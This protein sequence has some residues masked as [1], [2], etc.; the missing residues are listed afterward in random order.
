[1]KVRSSAL[2]ALLLLASSIT[3]A[4]QAAAPRPITV[5]DLFNVKEA[6]EARINPDG[7]AI[8]FTVHSTSLKEDKPE[9]RIW[10]VPAVGGE[11]IPLTAGGVESSHPRWS[12]DGKY[13]AFLS[14]RKN[15]EGDDEK[16]Q[17][18]V[19]N[20]LG[21]EAQ[22]LTDTAQDVEEFEWAPSGKQLVLILRDPTPEEAEAAA[23][24]SR[25]A[26]GSQKKKSKAQPPWVLDRL[27][28]KSDT[29][30]YI[31]RRRTHLYVFNLADKSQ[32]QV[33]SGDYDDAQPAWSPDGKS[34]AFSSNRTKPEPDATYNSDIW[35]VAADNTNQGAHPAQVT[36]FP[37]QKDHPAWSP[38]GK[39]LTYSASSD[40]KLFYYATKHVAL[41]SATG[42][43]AR[44]LTK[45]LDRMATEPQFAPD[46]KSIYF[47]ADDDG[48]QTV[49]QVN[50]AD[51]IVTRAI[52]GRLNVDGYSLSKD[53]TLAATISTTDRPYEVFTIPGGKLTRLTHL[54]DDWLAQHKVV[55][56]EYVSF[57]SKDGTVV[58]GYLYKP[59]DYRPGKKVPTILRPHGGP[60][61]EYEDEFFDL[62]Q[63]FAANGY[64]VL[65][66]NPRGSTGYGQEFCKAIYA[67]WGNKDF[68]DDM[69]FVDYALAQGLADPDKLGVGGWSYGGISTDFI[70]GQTNRFK[71]AITGAGAAN[72]TSMWGHDQYQREY[73]IELGYPWENQVLWDRIAPFYRVKNILTPTLFVGGNIDC[74]VPILGGEQM[75]LSLKE[76]GRETLLVVY[77]DEYHEFKTPSHIKDLQQ[78][79]LAWYAH[80]VKADGTPARPA[81]TKET[82][83]AN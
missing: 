65:L 13:L 28:F 49:A 68:Q 52:G 82:H 22:R 35:V 70:I 73:V 79:Y 54:N 60:V 80:Y 55:K 12:P 19:L 81:P 51:E 20:R 11:A 6:H 62:A 30:G 39:W 29:I 7:Q 21:G 71:A 46:G 47:L 74:N 17:V 23:A 38:D 2:L 34:L 69:A 72:F 83:P 16:T 66:P 50:L 53:G 67:D 42:G 32:R 43:D 56:G 25:D 59:V 63:L 24:K 3:P 44:I 9:S 48:T 8:A 14:T 78:R 37:G 36:N 75:Y 77:P 76:L 10:M 57:K 18:Y 33:S 41:S 1:M 26:E 45:A 40:L 15:A 27:Q 5:D 64:A 58:H 4:Q 61:E 31:D